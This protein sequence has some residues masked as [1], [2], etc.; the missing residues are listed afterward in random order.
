[1][2]LTFEEF[3][4]RDFRIKCHS[5]G[6]W[7]RHHPTKKTPLKRRSKP[8]AGCCVECPLTCEQKERLEWYLR[9]T[10]RWPLEDAP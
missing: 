2:T 1:M 6:R 7:M 8:V 5:C 9:T 4:A 10:G 3:R